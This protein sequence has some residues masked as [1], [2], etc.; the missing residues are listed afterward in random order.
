MKI[1]LT[2]IV[3][4]I[5]V[6]LV[7]CSTRYKDNAPLLSELQQAEAI[8]YTDT[9]SAL[10][11]LQSMPIPSNSDRLQHATWSLLMAE[12]LYKSYVPQNDSL[13]NIACDYFLTRDDA[14]RRSLSLYLKGC[15][16]NENHREDEALPLLLQASED[17]AK[18]TEYR[19]GH[20]NEAEI[21]IMYERRRFYVD[22]I[23]HLNKALD[24][25]VQ[26]GDSNYI[27][28]SYRY[29]ARI[30]DL[31]GDYD[32]AISLYS[33]GIEFARESTLAQSQ[34]YNELAMVF[35]HKKDYP[36]AITNVKKSLEIKSKINYSLAEGYLILARIFHETGKNDSALYYLD[37]AKNT[38]NLYT[39]RGVY[40]LLRTISKEKKDYLK[41]DTYADN[42]IVILDSIKQ[43]DRNEA[44]LEIQAKYDNEKLLNQQ[45]TLKLKNLRLT[46]FLTFSV[47]A[48]AI[49][50]IV[51]SRLYK[52]FQ[53]KLAESRL[54]LQE[55]E[56][57]INLNQQEINR[58]TREIAEADINFNEKANLIMMQNGLLQKQNKNLMDYFSNNMP[59]LKTLKEHPKA[60]KDWKPIYELTDALQMNCY[61]RLKNGIPEM[62]D[63]SLNICCLIRLGFTTKQIAAI[64]GI[65]AESLTKRKGRIR[66]EIMSNHPDMFNQKVPLDDFILSF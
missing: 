51:G 34:L 42:L 30:P 6:L 26:F 8:M 3:L 58:M 15:I 59:L 62:P 49:I 33:K 38:S 55:S 1:S 22:A 25:A 56:R 16:Y 19:L 29:L 2:T 44:L 28:A 37:I 18:T 50:V 23:K 4:I 41:A 48:I 65:E 20:L 60:I 40:R 53:C 24:Y 11:I 52:F 43:I 31:Q 61:T 14:G 12:A 17:I 45:A 66:D 32:Q 27:A 10:H 54:K 39:A 9:D 46:L 21:G 13:I 64:I 63:G 57:I 7:S 47:L 35:Q 5:V 36:L